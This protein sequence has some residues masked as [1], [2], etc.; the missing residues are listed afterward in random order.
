[1]SF[2]FSV[3]RWKTKFFK[4]SWELLC[5]FVR[6]KCCF[7]PNP[8]QG[9]PR[10]I[11]QE[12]PEKIEGLLRSHEQLQFV[13]KLLQKSEISASLQVE[14]QQKIDRIRQRQQDPNLYLAVVGEFS[15]GKSTFI[16]A[17]LKEDL[18]KTSA[19]V[20]TAV[21]TK[22]TYGNQL[23]VEAQF[24]GSRASFITTDPKCQMVHLPWFSESI[25]I[26]HF[27]HMITSEEEI[28][29]DIVNL[30]IEHPASFLANG[31][32]IID[33]PGNNADNP[34]HSEIT[35][36]VVEQEADLAI[37]IIPATMPLSETLAK[38][39]TN[40]LQSYL[41]RCIFVVSR[42]DQIRSEEHSV[43][44]EDLSSRLVDKL[45]LCFPVVH[46][47]SAQVSLDILTGK[48]SVAEDLQVWQERFTSLEQL[49][50]DRLSRE[51]ILSIAESLLR[52]LTPLFNQLESHLQSQWQQYK[53]RQTEI[54]RETIPNLSEFTA[55]Q[56]AICEKQLR[57]S[58]SSYL[59]RTTGCV[60]T[61]REISSNKIRTQLFG[62]TSEDALKN[63]LQSEIQ[64]F[65]TKE[66]NTL[67]QELQKLTHTLAE[68]ATAV[69]RIFDQKFAEVYHRLQSIGGKLEASAN[70]HYDFHTQP[71]NVTVSAQSL[72]QEFDSGDGTKMGIGATAG[73]V[74]GSALIPGLGSLVGLALGTW[75]S[76]FFVPSLEERKQKLWEQL[77]PGIDSYFDTLQTQSNEAALTY[78][79]SL[80]CSL[81]QRID[82]YVEKYQQI[83]EELLRSQKAELQRLTKLQ[84]ST[85]ADLVEIERRKHYLTEK[86]QKL[87][88]FRV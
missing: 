58:I 63:V 82:F 79:Q 74:I 38:F 66:Q 28:A 84:K 55:E 61:H 10:M 4:T 35:K 2:A 50:I 87:A 77:K 30:K 57:N 25:N 48:E 65:L 14:L 18:L 88:T 70:S 29:K 83:V 81:K 53:S 85:Q 32:V 59:S 45:N 3:A 68:D 16:N 20:A 42:M 51:R 46:P 43:L 12:M 40:S 15:S 72:T 11:D 33:T 75:A 24:S 47:C 23:R 44:L 37:I 54:K 49:I 41:H 86:Q 7:A 6:V 1:M 60:D 56:Y 9:I 21:A 73:F 39:L 36:Q 26:R 5:I 78:T 22:I 8:C 62:V 27:V 19:L 76:R 67:Q 69:G 52:L 13:E 31:I 64:N 34:V 80:E 71:S 17:L